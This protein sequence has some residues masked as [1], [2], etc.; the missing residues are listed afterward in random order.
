[1]AVTPAGGMMVAAAVG[2]GRVDT[3][4]GGRRGIGVGDPGAGTGGRGVGL[5]D[6]G[7]TTGAA[8]GR[9]VDAE[10][11][12]GLGDGATA[13]VREVVHPAAASRMDRPAVASRFVNAGPLR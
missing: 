5:G 12:G 8:T 13:A 10:G 1:M 6:G 7:S 4:A 11:N 9:D 2:S 3:A